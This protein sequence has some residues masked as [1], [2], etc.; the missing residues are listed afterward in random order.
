MKE[1][2]SEKA[3]KEQAF[4]D[5]KEITEESQQSSRPDRVSMQQA[6]PLGRLILSFANTP[7]QYTRLTKRA[8]LDLINGR[9]DWKTNVSK[10]AYYGAVQNIIFTALQSALFALAFSDEED[11]KE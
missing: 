7:M 8:A 3:A 1:G 5:F 10:L 6:S 4:L 11:E 9:G 2:L